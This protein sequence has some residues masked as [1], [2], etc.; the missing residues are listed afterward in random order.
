[1]EYNKKKSKKRK[2]SKSKIFYTTR[3]QKNQPTEYNNMKK[4]RKNIKKKSKMNA[5]NRKSMI[6]ARKNHTKKSKVSAQIKKYKANV[7]KKNRE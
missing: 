3:M 6:K 2:Y 7:K 4:G 1:M 5:Q